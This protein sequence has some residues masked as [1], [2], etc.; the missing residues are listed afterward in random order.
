M[1]FDTLIKIITP[2]I[3]VIIAIISFIPVILSYFLIDRISSIM[4]KKVRKFL[5]FCPRFKEF[6]GLDALFKESDKYSNFVYLFLLI[7]LGLMIYVYPN[8][9]LMFL[10]WLYS[11]LLTGI[12]LVVSIIFLVLL[13]RKASKTLI[14]IYNIYRGIVYS[15]LA[16]GLVSSMILAQGNFPL[17]ILSLVYFYVPIFFDFRAMTRVGEFINKNI[18]HKL[19]TDIR[20]SPR[21]TIFTSRET[22]KISGKIKDLFNEEF[23]ILQEGNKD[24]MIP[25][26]EI[27]FIEC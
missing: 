10:S 8:P 5:Y 4:R 15:I 3:P 19:Q 18:N 9:S 16:V 12:F 11:V 23:L 17:I 27:K 14:K 6:I 22:E 26:T 7:A 1:D 2:F 24:I 25:W 13:T 21:V 20:N